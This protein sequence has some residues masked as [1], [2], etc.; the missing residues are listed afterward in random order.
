MSFI[1]PHH[2]PL[3]EERLRRRAS[4]NA[5]ASLYDAARPDY[6]EAL[7]DDLMSL[8]GVAVGAAVLEIGGGTGKA[9][10]PLAKRGLSILGIELGEQMAA[11]ARQKLAAY[12]QVRIEVSAFEEWPLPEGAFDL[13]VSASA[14]HWIDPAIGYAKVARALKPAGKFALMW[15]SQRHANSR[16]RHNHLSDIENAEN[17]DDADDAFTQA[18]QE[19]ARSTAPEL[20]HIRADRPNAGAHRFVRADALEASGYFNAPEVRTYSWETIY[21]TASYLRLLDSYSS[22]RVLEPGLHQRLFEAIGAMIE[23]RFGGTVTRSWRAELY[24]AQR[25]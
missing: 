23:T 19:V 6:P 18:L 1:P 21:N 9:T 11:L 16:A 12:P 10:L 14:W 15:S 3:D 5:D 8:S 24:L 2:H 20:A 22:Y 4:F 17:A 7:F 25:R 13:A